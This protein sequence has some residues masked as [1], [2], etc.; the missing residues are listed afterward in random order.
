MQFSTF[1]C[2]FSTSVAFIRGRLTVKSCIKAAAYVLFFN[3]LCGFYSSAAFIW[4]W[5]ICKILSL[6]TCKSGLAHVKWKWNF[7][8]RLF[9][10]YFQCKQ[11]FGMRKVWFSST[12]TTQDR[13]FRAAASI[14]VRLMCSL[15]SE[16]VRLLIKCGF[17]TRLYGICNALSRQNE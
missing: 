13:F 7:T 3:F 9:K 10:N 8:L 15:S 14:R 11:T 1:C 6:Q 17:Y 16:K 2:G 5:L 4:G 12:L